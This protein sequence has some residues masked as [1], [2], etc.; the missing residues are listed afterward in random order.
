MKRSNVS[1]ALLILALLVIGVSSPGCNDHGE[2]QMAYDRI[3]VKY[4]QCGFGEGLVWIEEQCS[5]VV[6][7]YS[8]CIKDAS[9]RTLR[10][11]DPDGEEEYAACVGAC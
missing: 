5:E 7:C 4:L 9:C 3:R 1:G 6:W 2:C 11:N 10:G 8:A